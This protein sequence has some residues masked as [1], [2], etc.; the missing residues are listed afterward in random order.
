MAL[1]SIQI[2]PQLVQAVRDAADIVSIASEHTRLKKSGQRY[3]GLCP[4]HKEKTPSF[5]VDSAQG[6]FY[7]FG[8]GQGGDAI[9]LHELLSGDDF[10]A[11]I[12][13]LA[14][15]YGIPLPTRRRRRGEKEGPEIGRALEAAAEFFVE[16]LA[17]TEMP[18]RYLEKRKISPQLIERYGLGYAPDDWRSLLGALNPRIPMAELEAAGLVA[19]S[20][21]SGEPY[22]R[23]RNRLIFPIRTVSG[24]LVGFGGRALG[25]DRAKYLNSA[26]SDEFKKSR[27]LY[28]LD[29]A[30]RAVRE[31]GKVMLVEGYFDVLGAVAA[32]IDWCVASMGTALTADQARMLGRYADEVVIGYDGD[33]AGERAARKAMALLLGEG[34]GVTRP[35]LGSHDPDSLRL[36]EGDEALRRAVDQAEDAVLL[37]IKRLSEGDVARSPRHQATAARQV[38]ELLRPIRDSI[39][40]YSYGRRAADRLG[41]PVELLWRR[42]GVDREALVADAVSGEPVP[43]RSRQVRS[44]EERV[45]Q[46]LFA[47]E[48]LLKEDALPADEIFLDPACR[49]IYRTF[50]DLYRRE[51]SPPDARDVLSSLGTDQAAVDEMAQL[52]LEIPVASEGFGLRESL[53]K[54]ERR[55]QQTRLREL[56]DEITRAERRGDRESLERLLATKTE[57]S[58]AL[59]QQ[60]VPERNEDES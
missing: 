44:L 11:A 37:E 42:L 39:L 31:A 20:R 56:A 19:K 13:S 55:R 6:L 46:G 30:K 8:C 21:K 1:S 14:R 7:C 51:G 54:L 57:L 59:H 2:T 53:R 50:S 4:L 60:Q 43:A 41:V 23:F 12:E 29:Q 26:E 17:K 18:G 10:P 52:L 40:R 15:Q 22:D 34:V 32:G 5:S 25:D 3:S 58:R 38:S 27:L 48:E 49:N 28:G 24:R 47:G 36:E 16:Q 45:I 33:E 9:R 35:E